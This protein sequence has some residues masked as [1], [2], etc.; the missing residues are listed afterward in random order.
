MKL[1]QCDGCKKNA[2]IFKNLT[3]DGVRYKL[4]IQCVRTKDLKL[5]P[6]ATQIKKR[7][8]KKKIEDRVYT[9]LRTV[10]L[11]KNEYCE[12]QTK[13]CTNRATEIHH[14]AYRTGDNYLNVNTWK[15]TCSTCHKWVHLN[16]KEARELKLLI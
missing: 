12:I 16:S 7:S 2:P 8:D 11:N 6:N 9:K 15:A 13:D 1:K 10:Y 4:C 3:E 5:K 14:T